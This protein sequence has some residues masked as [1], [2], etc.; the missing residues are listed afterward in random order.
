MGAWGWLA[1]PRAFW[2]LSVL[3]PA[4]ALT[5]GNMDTQ[6]PRLFSS[7]E[8]QTPNPSFIHSNLL[9]IEILNH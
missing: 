2:E 9:G 7:S 1:S 3:F 5:F 4:L 6:G 8:A